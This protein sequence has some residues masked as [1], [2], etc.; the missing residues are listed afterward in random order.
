MQKRSY[1]YWQRGRKL[2]AR[3]L[4]LEPKALIV[5]FIGAFWGIA[6]IGLLATLYL[7]AT[8][9]FF[10]IGSFGATAVLVFA[11][12]QSP[13]AQ[14]HYLFAG[15][16]LS[17]LVGVT[18]GRYVPGPQ[19]LTAALA[20]SLAIT[21]MQATRCLHPPGGAT[22]L[23]AVM[24]SDRIQALGYLYVL[25]PVLT[26]VHAYEAA[27]DIG[28]HLGIAP[29]NLY[30]LRPDTRQ[31]LEAATGLTFSEG[32]EY[33]SHRDVYDMFSPLNEDEAEEILWALGPQTV[34]NII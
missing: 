31:S 22:A 7:A 18:I 8:D 14:P 13:L 33:V 6:T 19:W 20:V 29:R 4:S 10:L 16:V 30:L 1:R 26:K 15:H 3:Q 34:R 11:A 2:A 9:S 23:I 17:A 28:T 24:G 12:P 21:A 25:T 32:K 5:T 27:R